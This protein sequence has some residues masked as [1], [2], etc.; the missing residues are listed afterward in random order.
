VNQVTPVSRELRYLSLNSAGSATAQRVGTA[1]PLRAY[2]TESLFDVGADA[3]V[4]LV[5]SENSVG[6]TRISISD[7]GRYNSGRVATQPDRRTAQ[8][9]LARRPWN[10]DS[11]SKA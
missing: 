6:A 3:L 2:S 11:S 9:S 4:L 10:L 5:P 7:G 8:C 1:S